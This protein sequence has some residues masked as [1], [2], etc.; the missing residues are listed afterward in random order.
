VD[1]YHW[2]AVLRS[3]SAF[4]TYKRV[5]RDVISPIKVAELLLLREDF[6]RSL[7]CCMADVYSI[8]KQLAPEPRAEVL[9]LAGEIHAHLRFG[10]IEQIFDE[11]LHEYLTDFLKRI[12]DLSGEIHDTYFRPP[13]MPIEQQA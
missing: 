1:Y 9:R 7:Q 12:N 8:I 4:E 13:V 3:V 5:Y 2:G 10:R 11:G 6:P